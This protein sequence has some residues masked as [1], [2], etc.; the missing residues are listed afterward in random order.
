MG[1]RNKKLFSHINSAAAAPKTFDL[2][3]KKKRIDDNNTDNNK[4]KIT[5]KYKPKRYKKN[6]RNIIIKIG[7]NRKFNLLLLIFM[8]KRIKEMSLQYKIKKVLFNLYEKKL[9][10]LTEEYNEMIL[11]KYNCLSSKVISR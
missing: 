11:E 9:D 8:K 4:N 5:E 1:K 10:I 6:K 2:N 3:N 7:K